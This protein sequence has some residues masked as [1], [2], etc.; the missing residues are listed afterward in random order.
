MGRGA[1]DQGKATRIPLGCQLTLTLFPGVTNYQ[2]DPDMPP[3]YH[4]QKCKNLKK[5]P[6]PHFASKA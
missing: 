6:K 5:I 4:E 3:P 2:V 1:F